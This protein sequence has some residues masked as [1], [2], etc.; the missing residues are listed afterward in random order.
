M[1]PTAPAPAPV[2]AP[3]TVQPPSPAAAPAL[4][5]VQPGPFPAAPRT[6][7]PAPEQHPVNPAPA[8]PAPPRRTLLLAG[9]AAAAVVGAVSAGAVLPRMLG[10]ATSP[11]SDVADGDA[12]LEA[13][14]WADD[15]GVLPA[16]GGAFSPEAVVTRGEVAAALHRFAGTPAVPLEDVPV[17]IVDL[18]EDPEQASALLWLHGRGALWGDAELK[19]H[20]DDPATREGASGMLAA[21][22]RPALAGIGAVWPSSGA[23]GSGGAEGKDLPAGLSQDA[24]WLTNAGMAPDGSTHWQGEQSV[25]RAELAAVLHRA[26][27]VIASALG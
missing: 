24:A 4:P 8:R 22:L 21:L 15:T 18:G 17:L 13:M 11:F 27:G 25:T 14:L 5:E 16:A 10:P 3:T 9:A 26:D 12:G 23:D 6:V 7:A 20:P 2:E 19:V 1:T